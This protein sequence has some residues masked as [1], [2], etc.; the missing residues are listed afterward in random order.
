MKL[1]FM[2]ANR[3]VTG[4][5]YCLDVG[6][7]RVMIDCGMFQ[8]RDFVKRNWDECPIDVRSVDALILTHA[9]I[10][11]S[12][13]IPRL[14][15]QGFRGKIYLT[16][17]T[18][19]LAQLL[20]ADSAKIQAEDVK[21]KKRR[22]KKEQRTSRH[23]I[24]PLFDIKD[25]ELAVSLFES[26][27]YDSW[28]E[29]AGGMR[30][31]FREAGHILGSAMVEIETQETRAE[32]AGVQSRK[33]IFSGDIGQWDKPLIRDPTLF[34]DADY[35]V[36][37]STYGD[38]DHPVDVPGIAEQLSDVLNRTLIRGGNVVI[39]TFAV[40][41]A[42]ELMY[43]IG[44]LV[45]EDRIPD[46]EVFLDS[47]MAIDVTDVFRRHR[48]CYDQETWDR[49][50][51]NQPPLRFPGLTMTDKV[52]QSRA[53]N[54]HKD[55]C[56]IMATSGM[57][58]AGRIKHHLRQNIHR[59]VSTILFVGFQGRGSLGRRILDGDESVRIHG[60]EY[61]VRAEVKRIDGFSAHADRRALLRWLAAFDCQ[62]KT[63]FLT[64]GEEKS[65]K[66]LANTIGDIRPGQ[67]VLVPEYGQEVELT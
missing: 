12:G 13:M 44:Q 56:I 65:A 27:P 55:P 67:Q 46:V 24:E 9:H 6:D 25:V 52:D 37:E 14:V 1:R 32:S 62:P 28:F 8:E 29:P 60:R 57:C 63:I 34:S 43:H 20:L 10:D 40:E 47:P 53:I 41:R 3:Q 11:H 38:R 7:Q 16:S 48:D 49:I 21:Y 17:A 30:A 58:E 4:S 18:N 51:A 42:Q 35:I 50:I 39:P 26:I 66:A 61:P 15:R 64:H 45:H 5:R 31:R 22:H 2:G 19:E 36:M 23:P 33:I 54:R 59:E